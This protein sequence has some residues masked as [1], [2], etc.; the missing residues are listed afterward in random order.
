MIIDQGSDKF[1]ETLDR[2]DMIIYSAT[3]Q[4]KEELIKQGKLNKDGTL[5]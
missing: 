2:L 1:N 4:A 5:R 3:E